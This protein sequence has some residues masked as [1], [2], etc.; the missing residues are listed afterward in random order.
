MSWMKS[1]IIGG[2]GIGEALLRDGGNRISQATPYGNFE[3]MQRE[4]GVLIVARHGS[5]HKQPPHKVPYLAIAAGLRHLGVRQCVSSAAVGSLDPALAPG[6]LA[7]VVDFMDFTGRNLTLYESEVEHTDFTPG[8]SPRLAQKLK[9]S[10]VQQT[11]VYAC[12]N[13]PRYETPAEIRALRTL[14]ADVVGMT[15]ATEAI[16]MKEAGIE[17]GSLAIITN[18]AAGVAG[19]AELSHAEV[20]AVSQ[21]AT[22]E[23]V[24]HLLNAIQ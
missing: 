18:F 17:Y 2:T 22:A 12:T 21:N 19:D 24:R 1:A 13:G 5:G 3:A 15:V 4:D 7:N 9:E 16:A 8:L 11:V 14:G 23:V 20:A 10:G 6:S